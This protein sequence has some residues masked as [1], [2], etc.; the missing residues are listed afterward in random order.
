MNP[1]RELDAG[2]VL[3][4]LAAGTEAGRFRTVLFG[5]F[6]L[7][8]HGVERL[9]MDIDVMLTEG[10]VD[11]FGDWMQPLGYRQV[12]RTPQYAKFRQAGND[13][14]LPDIDTV[15]V[16]LPVMD[17]IWD[18]AS[19]P[20]TAPAPVRVASLQVMV[21]TKLHAL[22]YNAEHRAERHDLADIV[23]MLRA[24]HIAP[25]DPWLRDLCGKYGTDELWQQLRQRL[26]A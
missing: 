16:D 7:P 25:D 1:P 3:V 13:A 10:D 15:F 9:T 21:G 24:A 19:V 4:R 18:D 17:R 22:K 2:D 26:K 11:A 14:G 12:L 23:G 5:G 20:A 8:F 6:A